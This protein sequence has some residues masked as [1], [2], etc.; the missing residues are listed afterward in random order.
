LKGAIRVARREKDGSE[1][2]ASLTLQPRNAANPRIGS[3]MQQACEPP[4]GESRRGG[5]K[6]RG[7]N[8]TSTLAGRSRR[9][10]VRFAGRSPGVDATR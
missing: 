10:D 3:R 6:P 2:L 5:E 8:G 4:R 7:R 9:R 1:T